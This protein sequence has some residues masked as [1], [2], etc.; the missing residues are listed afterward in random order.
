M[1]FFTRLVAAMIL[2]LS[3]PVT[4]QAIS[5]SQSRVSLAASRSSIELGGRV[6]LHG[7]VSGSRHCRPHHHSS[8]TI[9]RNG[10]PVAIVATDASGAFSF[11]SRADASSS[12]SALFRG[13][14]CHHHP[15]RTIVFASVSRPVTVMVTVD[16]EAIR[17][18]PRPRI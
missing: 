3:M 7:F 4:A 14:R 15:N 18:G 6:A 9:F 11:S 13:N 17:P 16:G 1:K 2:V 5:I 8:V 12:W 10:V